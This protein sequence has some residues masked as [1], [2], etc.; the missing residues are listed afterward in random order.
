MTKLPRLA[1]SRP[2]PRVRQPSLPGSASLLR[3]ASV[4]AV[5]TWR[6]RLIALLLAGMMSTAATIHAQ[7]HPRLLVT[8]QRLAQLRELV[9][10]EG[11]HHAQVYE[12]MKWRV[13][14]ADLTEAYHEPI[15]AYSRSYRAREAAMLSLLAADQAERKRYADIAFDTLE[16]SF[17]DPDTA[18]RT[19]T[20]G[21]G[22]ARAM[23][24]LGTALAYDWCYNTW[25][26]DQR[27]RVREKMIEALDAWPRFGHANLR[28][29]GTSNWVAVTRGGELMLML[30]AGEEEHRN[31]RYEE[32][33]RQ[34][35]RHM[36]TAFDDLGVTQEGVGYAEYP[37]GFLLPSVFAT[38]QL[39]D[40]E[41]WRQAQR[42]N[43]WRMAM[44]THAFT[45][46]GRKFVQT[47]VAHSGNFNEGWTSLLFHTVTQDE[48][49]YY[50]YF[51]DRHMGK[52]SRMPLN[53]RFDGD[54]AGAVYALLYYRE[55]VEPRDPTGRMPVGVGGQRGWHFFRSQWK[56]DSDLL[57]SLAA[58]TQ[59]RSHAWAQPETFAINLLAYNTRFIGGPGKNREQT[60]YS[61]LLVDGRYNTDQTARATGERGE[62]EADP[63]RGYAIV[64]GGELYRALGAGQAQRHL[65][66]DFSR[67]Q[68]VI[69][70]TYDRARSGEDRAWTWQAN[71]G[72]DRGD[73]GVEAELKPDGDRPG[74][75]LRGRHDSYVRGWVLHPS[76]ARLGR[77][78]D[79]LQIETA[80]RE[81]D[82]L[83]VMLVGRGEPPAA[84]IEG[85]GM[86]TV[87]HVDG[88]QV[89][90]DAARGRIVVSPHPASK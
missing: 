58:K 28:H 12:Q 10:K 57:T 22:L 18:N 88:R 76:D 54:R 73:D 68:Q 86:D 25:N 50:R 16:Q 70:A 69:V 72:D 77:K 27:R 89:R 51:Y 1:L 74:F 39:G 7:Q 2:F 66:N 8:E 4:R 78:D 83:V 85:R 3:M 55:D 32:L 62:F 60:F 45:D 13:D 23:M 20:R 81:A 29:P 5:R 56:D 11:T 43:W 59:Q 84:R 52:L 9:R 63:Q 87:L 33:K 46:I 75:L 49:G 64:H 24:S 6:T 44:Y 82:I 35:V 48:V 53:R 14:E 61:T 42:H 38:K 67:P 80:G 37:G 30:A 47:G 79:A 26:E 41:L 65:M 36:G 15:F 19:M 71:L 21:T 17:T 31:K 90:Y 40:D 34:L